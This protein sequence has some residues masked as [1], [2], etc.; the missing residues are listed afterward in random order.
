MGRQHGQTF[1]AAA[2]QTAHFIYY[3]STQSLQLRQIRLVLF[4][5]TSKHNIIHQ[6]EKLQVQ[7]W[8]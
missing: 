3:Y 5:S 1:Q 6:K 7:C 4:S 8:W 2:A